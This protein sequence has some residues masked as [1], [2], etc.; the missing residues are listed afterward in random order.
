[1]SAFSQAS[2]GP[3]L[4]VHN[5]AM[6]PQGPIKT[7]LPGAPVGTYRFDCT[8]QSPGKKA[9]SVKG[10]VA[11]HTP[12]GVLLTTVRYTKPGNVWVV[13]RTPGEPISIDHP[14][15]F[16]WLLSPVKAPLPPT[17]VWDGLTP[18]YNHRMLLR[19]KAIKTQ[20]DKDPQDFI[21]PGFYNR[22]RE[23]TQTMAYDKGHPSLGWS[24]YSDVDFKG[25]LFV[26]IENKWVVVGV[27]KDSGKGS[28]F[29]SED[30]SVLDFI[31][32][33]RWMFVGM[34]DEHH[35]FRAFRLHNDVRPQDDDAVRDD[36]DMNQI[37][38]SSVD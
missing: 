2:T 34:A 28:V 27:E 29:F 20:F 24:T 31:G 25:R 13:E 21:E 1:M 16:D 11:M 3:F 36:G 15:V 30:D 12:Q 8:V 23:K 7:Y 37:H 18:L 9:T 22:V 35:G 4:E 38:E 26:L 6:G 32:E 17:D 10:V 5:F 14:E 19:W 33:S